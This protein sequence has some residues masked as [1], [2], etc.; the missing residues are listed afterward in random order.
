MT[1]LTAAQRELLERMA[2]GM[3]LS[4]RVS[5]P[6]DEWEFTISKPAH[7]FLGDVVDA[8]DVSPLEQTGFIIREDVGWS[9]RIVMFSIT[10]AGRAALKGEGE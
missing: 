4:G 3:V 2:A 9:G 10:D 6:R 7:V 8:E 1:K 5:W